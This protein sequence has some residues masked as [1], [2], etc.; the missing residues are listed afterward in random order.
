MYQVN[1][2]FRTFRCMHQRRKTDV[3][4]RVDVVRWTGIQEVAHAREVPL[5]DEIMKFVERAY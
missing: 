1:I 4:V 5:L 2:R 3:V